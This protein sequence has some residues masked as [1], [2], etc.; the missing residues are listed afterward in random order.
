M[1]GWEKR[2]SEK[3]ANDIL[4]ETV[5]FFV[6]FAH[7]CLAQAIEL[8]PQNYLG[9]MK[10]SQAHVGAERLKEATLDLKQVAVVQLL[11]L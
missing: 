6:C 1:N 5:V 9:Y 11:W 3:L 2:A 8:D 10:R 7:P 4:V